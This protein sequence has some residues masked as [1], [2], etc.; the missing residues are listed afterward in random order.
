MSYIF[1]PNVTII[2]I[3]YSFALVIQQGKTAITEDYVIT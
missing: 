1:V 2:H 3:L